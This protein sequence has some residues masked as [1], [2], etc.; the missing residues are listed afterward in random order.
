MARLA[1][2]VPAEHGEPDAGVVRKVAVA[3]D[4]HAGGARGAR[5][6]GREERVAA[7]GAEEVLLVVRSLAEPVVVERD[8]ALVDDRRL[9]V[10]APWREYL[11]PHHI[12]TIS[13]YRKVGARTSW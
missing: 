3:A 5:G 11:P 2:R 7:L 6:G 4:R 12:N 10:V 1:V 9:A 8:E 13:P